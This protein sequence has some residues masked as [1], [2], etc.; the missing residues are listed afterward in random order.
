MA[1]FSDK[2]IWTGDNLDVMRGLDSASVDLIYADPPFNA[3]SNFAASA[4]SAFVGPSFKASWTP[5]EL[6]IAWMGV[7]ADEDPAVYQLLRTAGFTHGHSM[8][9]YLCMMAVRLIEMRRV[10]KETG[11]IYLHCDSTNSH[12]LKLLMDTI[13]GP[14]NFRN[15]IAWRRTK[16]RG[17]TSRG[18]PDNSNSLLFYTSTSDFTWKPPFLPHDPAYVERFYRHIEPETGRPYRLGSLTSSNLDRPDLTYEW[19]GHAKI[20]RWTK[21]HM[22]EA[23]NQGL[24]H[25]S[26]SGL[27]SQKRYLDQANGVPIDTIWEDI[28][29]I[30]GH[31]MEWLGYPGQQPL[32][33][34]ER[35]IETSSSIGDTVLDPFCGSATTCVAAEMLGRRWVAIDVSPESVEVLK[36]RFEQCFADKYYPE[37]IIARNDIPRRTDIGTRLPRRQIKHILYGQQ[38]GRC[39]GCGSI[40]DFRDLYFDHILPVVA[41]GTD[42]LENLQLLCSHCNQIKGSHSQERLL[43][44]LRE[45]GFNDE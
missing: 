17:L 30:Q 43:A 21:E 37:L 42:E 34:L 29:P 22:Q 33:L 28:Q 25:Y 4:G 23:H 18:Y 38:D 15:E 12:F 16:T 11:S 32:A 6:D 44:R 7:I 8:Q 10:L 39:N 27:A 13:Y 26:S 40:F 36:R 24:L 14:E 1:N 41:G 2:T 9:Y 5:S 3:R 31:S 45:M 35:V 19:N 20:W